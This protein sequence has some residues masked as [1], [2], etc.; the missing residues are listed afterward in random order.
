MAGASSAHRLLQHVR[1]RADGQQRP[2]QAPGDDLRYRLEGTARR[3]LGCLLR[4]LVLAKN[5]DDLRRRQAS[6]Q[7]GPL[8][9]CSCSL[10]APLIEVSNQQDK[11]CMVAICHVCRIAVLKGGKSVPPRLRTLP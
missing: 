9:R 3:A 1:E 2:V 11:F 10:H 5:S 4:C 8:K 6:A 7:S